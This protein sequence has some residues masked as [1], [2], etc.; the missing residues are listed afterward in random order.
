MHTPDSTANN[1]QLVRYHLDLPAMQ[2]DEH[3]VAVRTLLMEHHL[4]VDHIGPGEAV[5]ASA[6]GTDPDWDVI[7]QA[8]KQAGFP[9]EYTTT[10]DS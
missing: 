5:V 8:L 10:S 2:S 4:L 6:S 1:N 7:K 3:L 9:A